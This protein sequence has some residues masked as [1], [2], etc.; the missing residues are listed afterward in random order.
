MKAIVLT[1]DNNAIFTDHMI[2][3]YMGL[4][5]DNPFDFIIPYQEQKFTEAPNK[6]FVRSPVNI[7]ATVLHL[8]EQIPDDEWIYWCIDDCYPVHLDIAGIQSIYSLIGETGIPGVSGINFCITNKK[9]RTERKQQFKKSGSVE[10]I[11]KFKAVEL[12]D[13]EQIWLHQFIRA[14]ALRHLFENIPEP[15]AGAKEMDETKSKVQKPQKHKLLMLEHD[16]AR[17]GESTARG[18]VTENCLKSMKSLGLFLDHERLS[19]GTAPGRLR[20]KMNLGRIIISKFKKL[21]S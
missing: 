9:A 12:H 20:G 18:K 6:T 15:R 11:G 10:E 7:R 19:N 2:R 21:F 1:Y 17:F 16:L 13:Y 4:W 8:L 3:K 14:G 5:P